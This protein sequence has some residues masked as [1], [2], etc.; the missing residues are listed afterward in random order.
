MPFPHHV[1]VPPDG[2]VANSQGIDV[3]NSRR[4]YKQNQ[5]EK[6]HL[7][8]L[9]GLHDT[10]QYGKIKLIQDLL[11]NS[12][13]LFIALT[14]THLNDNVLSAEL[15]IENYTLF[16]SDRINRKCG[17]VAL[18]VRDGLGSCEVLKFSNEDCES[19]IVKI[20]KVKPLIITVY[21]FISG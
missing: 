6:C 8:N 20:E 15:D 2:R 14:E 12:D 7:L 3:L 17:G 9:Q 10:G 4:A 18:Y 13:S 16:R 5:L 11:S 1:A 19:R 21:S